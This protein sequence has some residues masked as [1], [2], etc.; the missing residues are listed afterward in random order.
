MDEVK[1]EVCDLKP[2]IREEILEELKRKPPNVCYRFIDKR[3]IIVAKGL[4]LQA[5]IEHAQPQQS[6]DTKTREKSYS[7]LCLVTHRIH[8][9]PDP[10]YLNNNVWNLSCLHSLDILKLF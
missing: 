4:R 8:Q 3:R 10:T 9:L 6:M 5:L 1:C 7:H 2:S